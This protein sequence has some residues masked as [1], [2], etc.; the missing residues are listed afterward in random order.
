M[1]LDGHALG[2]PRD[3]GEAVKM[4]TALSG[5]EH[6]VITGLAVIS[7]G[8]VYTDAVT[9]AV[10]FLPLTP[11]QIDW[12]VSTGEPMDKAGAYG[13]QG[14]GGML[15]EG[16]TGDYFNVVGLPVSRLARL[17]EAAGYKVF[18]RGRSS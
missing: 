3:E 2:K 9:T 8:A 5:R 10:R 15:I 7:R 11:E 16:I 6:R 4:L 1:F 14:L 13:I 18:S 12:Y 17:L